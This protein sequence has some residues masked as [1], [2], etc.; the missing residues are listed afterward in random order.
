[1][2]GMC[3]TQVVYYLFSCKEPYLIFSRF[4][5]FMLQDK[6]NVTLNHVL[7]N[8]ID[9]QKARTHVCMLDW[10]RTEPPV[11]LLTSLIAT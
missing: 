3:Y 10:D 9:A 4:T 6:D 5:S 11:C 1:M 8:P 7:Q 2:S